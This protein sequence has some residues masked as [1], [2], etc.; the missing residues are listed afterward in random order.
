MGE[1]PLKH[2][3]VVNLKWTASVLNRQRTSQGFV[4]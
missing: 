1:V 4:V 2:F 3:R